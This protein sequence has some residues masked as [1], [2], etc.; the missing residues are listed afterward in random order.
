M[1]VIYPGSFDPITFGHIDVIKRALKIF[2]EVIVS[3]A[4][5]PQK[6]L[7]FT[8]EERLKMVKRATK[9]L[10]N[11]KVE[12]FS[13]LVTDFAKK[14][15][16]NV[17]SRKNYKALKEGFEESLKVITPLLQEIER[18][19]RK[20]DRMGHELYGLTDEEIKVVEESL[21]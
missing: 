20:I 17:K 16:V 10:V 12:D 1:K 3:V 2:D 5:N 15:K 14:K 21:I 11:V 19:D 8:L 13:S 4:H 6:D 18:T 7:L 9:N